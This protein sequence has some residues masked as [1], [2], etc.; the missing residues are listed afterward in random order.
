MDEPFKTEPHPF[1]PFLPASARMLILGSFPPQPKRWCMDFYYPNW[2]NDFWRI[3]GNI[4]YSDRDHF[5]LPGEKRF[6]KEAIIRFCREQGIAL[7]DTATSIRRLKENASD[8]FLEVVEPTDIAALLKQIPRCQAIVT[9]GQKATDT[10]CQTFGCTQPPLNGS[11]G[12]IVDGKPY[13]FFRLP[14]TSRAYPLSLEKKTEAY[15][16]LFNFFK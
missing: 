11:V 13:R 14:S 12:I 3:M 5:T 9:T 7:Y 10:L 6:D 8:R 16:N 2:I 4:F 15:K 1:K